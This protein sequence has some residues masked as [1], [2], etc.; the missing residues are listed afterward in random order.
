MRFGVFF[1]WALAHLR[2]DAIAHIGLDNLDCELV[3][4]ERQAHNGRTYLQGAWDE[5]RQ[6]QKGQSKIQVLGLR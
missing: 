1:S 5:A 6:R 2:T 4:G 3:A